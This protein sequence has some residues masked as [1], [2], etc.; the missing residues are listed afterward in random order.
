MAELAATIVARCCD[1]NDQQIRIE[2]AGALPALV[3]L[4]TCGYSKAQ[5]AALDALAYLC[6]ENPEFGKAIVEAQGKAIGRTQDL[7]GFTRHM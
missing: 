7:I 4:L 6:H 5:E 2:Q 3:K 1:S